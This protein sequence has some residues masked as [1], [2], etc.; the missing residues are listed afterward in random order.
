VHT[1][2]QK[3]VTK[4][5]YSND[6]LLFAIANPIWQSWSPQD[7]KIVRDAAQ[8][9][10]RDNIQNVRSMFAQDVEKVLVR[11]ASRC[12]CRRRPRWSNGRSLRAVRTRGG[13][14]RSARR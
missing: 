6:I 10:A 11:W 14:R 7:Q 13:R 1:L 8:D 9:A 5:N 4:W 3:Y 2:G 12:M